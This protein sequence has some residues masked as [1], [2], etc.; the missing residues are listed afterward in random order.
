MEHDSGNYNNYNGGGVLQERFK[1]DAVPG[2]IKSDAHW[3]GVRLGA[4]Q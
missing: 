3:E 1:S 2:G 4:F